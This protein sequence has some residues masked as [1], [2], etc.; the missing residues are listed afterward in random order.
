MNNRWLTENKHRLK[1]LIAA[2]LAPSVSWRSLSVEEFATL[3]NDHVDI[4]RIHPDLQ[5]KAPKGDLQIEARG[6]AVII[7]DDLPVVMLLLAATELRVQT[8]QQIKR[9][10]DAIIA[11]NDFFCRENFGRVDSPSFAPP[12][13]GFVTERAHLMSGRTDL[14]DLFELT[15]KFAIEMQKKY[16]LII[17]GINAIIGNCG[18]IKTCILT[19]TGTILALD[20]ST[21]PATSRNALNDI[22]SYVGDNIRG[23]HTAAYLG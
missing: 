3:P 18:T 8:P 23:L 10:R 20:T 13:I 1:G 6:R 17:Q 15:E 22:I 11:E 9:T 19:M 7:T 16:V 21:M 2:G 5:I 4:L 14:V 12:Y